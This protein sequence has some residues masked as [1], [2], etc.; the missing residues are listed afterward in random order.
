MS[1]KTIS[2]KN[3]AVIKD[4]IL[5]KALRLK[6]R[7]SERYEDLYKRS[8]VDHVKLM[9]RR[10]QKNES[11][12]R[13]LILKAI[14][15]GHFDEQS[16]KIERRDYEML[17]HLIEADLDNINPN[18]LK[19]VMLSAMKMS[20]DFHHIL[21]LMSLEYAGKELGNTLVILAK[22]EV[23]NKVRLEEL[24]EEFVNKDYW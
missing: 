1:V 8:S 11:N 3:E 6:E 22:R 2:G 13:A 20:K 12:D 24:Y 23:E 17:D 5:R 9:L 16:L 21:D 7:I 15:N 14:K 18:D 10:L 19:S 4:D